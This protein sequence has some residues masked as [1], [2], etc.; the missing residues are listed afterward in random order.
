MQKKLHKKTKVSLKTQSVPL[1]G[2]KSQEFS[3][4]LSFSE[5]VLTSKK[6]ILLILPIQLSFP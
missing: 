5:K 6:E 2:S 4:R 3:L 1:L